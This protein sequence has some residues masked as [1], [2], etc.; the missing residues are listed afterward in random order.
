MANSSSTSL[1]TLANPSPTPDRPK[2]PV[3]PRPSPTWGSTAPPSLS[4]TPPPALLTS[5][6]LP[7]QLRQAVLIPACPAHQVPTPP[8]AVGTATIQCPF[9]IHKPHHRLPRQTQLTPNKSPRLDPVPSAR[10]A[11]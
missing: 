2:S 7:P 3:S 1:P 5:R 10:P 9:P 8:T 6:L 4:T 11:P